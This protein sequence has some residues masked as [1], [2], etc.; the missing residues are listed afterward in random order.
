[1]AA[2]LLLALLAGLTPG[3]TASDRCVEGTPLTSSAPLRPTQT[4][5]C[6]YDLD[7]LYRRMVA[8]LTVEE[9]RIDLESTERLFGLPRLHTAYDDPRWTSYSVQIG[10]GENDSQW[11]A[12]IQFGE[13]FYPLVDTRPLYF[14][15][16]ERPVHIRPGERG[17]IDLSIDVLAVRVGPDSPGCLTLARFV[18]QAAAAGW[19]PPDFPIWNPHGPPTLSFE[20][21]GLT[22]FPAS[23]LAGECLT[24]ITLNQAPDPPIAPVTDEEL[25][26]IRQQNA[27]LQ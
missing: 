19:K 4:A 11:T 6:P 26:R 16:S 23:G 22:L 13:G 9:G 5:Q 21:G 8:L 25:A 14:R 17:D 2:P 10:G 7:D 1:M 18:E 12:I 20:R 27:E 3:P 24:R 15:G